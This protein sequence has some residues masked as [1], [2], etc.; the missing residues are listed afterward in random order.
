MFEIGQGGRPFDERIRLLEQCEDPDAQGSTPPG[1]S[2]RSPVA[3]KSTSNLHSA[4]W[5]VMFHLNHGIE[6]HHQKD[7]PCPGEGGV[8]DPVETVLAAAE[9]SSLETLRRVLTSALVCDALDA[10]G[11]P[12]QSPRVPLRPMTADHT[13]VGRCRTTL[14][15]DMYHV[16]PRPYELELQAVDGSRPDDVLIA[17]A[18]GSMRSGLWGELLTAARGTRAASGSSSTGPS[19]TRAGSAR[20]AF[21]SSPAGH[22]PTTAETA[23]G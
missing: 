21:P 5:T 4:P 19:A 13:L 1:S 2:Q 8:S 10:E 6:P 23:S 7:H 18:G 9:E 22:A 16:D 14:W 17:A 20:W 15:A 12:H 11:F 3:I